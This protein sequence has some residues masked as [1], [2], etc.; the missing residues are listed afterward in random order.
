M[1]PPRPIQGT[2]SPKAARGRDSGVVAPRVF[3]ARGRS[4][5]FGRPCRSATTAKGEDPGGELVGPGKPG[6]RHWAVESN[7][8]MPT[9]TPAGGTGVD[10]LAEGEA[11]S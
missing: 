5:G 3:R 7:E 4:E 2:D 11:P 10:P 9:G 8:E 1:I 6:P